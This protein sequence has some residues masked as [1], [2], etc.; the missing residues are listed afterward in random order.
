MWKA[1]T[2]S[3]HYPANDTSHV[4]L[5]KK[6]QIS[7]DVCYLLKWGLLEWNPGKERKWSVYSSVDFLA[8]GKTAGM[9]SSSLGSSI[10]SL[11]G[12]MEMLGLIWKKEKS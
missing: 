1:V 2:K 9:F 8:I 11:S 7:L 3:Q 4:A 6:L 10:K 5:S 12:E